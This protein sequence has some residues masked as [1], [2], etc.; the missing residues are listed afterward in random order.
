MIAPVSQTISKFFSHQI[1]VPNIL[2]ITVQP[3]APSDR[4]VQDYLN[5]LLSTAR[6]FSD[7]NKKGGL[8]LDISNAKYLNAEQRILI[9]QAIKANSQLLN[10]GFVSLAYITTSVV[11][12]VVIK[13]INLIQPPPIPYRVCI[14]LMDAF[15]WTEQM[16]G[17][18]VV[19]NKTL[20]QNFRNRQM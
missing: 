11:S 17:L 8:I 15:K 7:Q 18:P 16:L 12:S 4:D 3:I 14:T 9:G 1:I 13:G 5:L 10:D 19:I 6:R 2:L 20:E